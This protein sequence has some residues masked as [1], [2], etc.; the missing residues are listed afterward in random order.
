MRGLRITLVGLSAAFLTACPSGDTTA[1]KDTPLPTVE[2]AEVGQYNLQ[3]ANGAAV[4]ASAGS[5]PI[6]NVTCNRFIDG[7][8]LTLDGK[9]SF[10]L[11]VSWRIVC[12]S[13]VNTTSTYSGIQASNGTWTYDGT[14]LTLS[15]QGGSAIG[16][17]NISA[18]GAAVTADLQLETEPPGSAFAFPLLT[19]RFQR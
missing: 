4:P 16:I 19:M 2:S 14:R 15:R 17:S 3:S 6:G 11:S 9:L 13:G 8:F 18:A 1:P 12:P 5:Y 7:G 10:Q